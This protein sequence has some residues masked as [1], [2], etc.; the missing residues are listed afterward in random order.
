M[1]ARVANYGRMMT[2][3]IVSAELRLTDPRAQL[4]DTKNAP[5]HAQG[6]IR[7]LNITCKYKTLLLENETA[8][9][10]AMTWHIRPWKRQRLHSSC[11]PAIP[12]T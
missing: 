11:R 6:Q 10:G 2:A 7:K 9:T 3:D 1:T 4:I 8:M 5:C 12:S